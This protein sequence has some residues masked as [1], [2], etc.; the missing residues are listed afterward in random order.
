MQIVRRE[1]AAIAVQVMHR[2]LVGH[3]RRKHMSFIHRERALAQIAGRAGG[4]DIVPGGDAA[5]RA[6]NDMIEGQ[7]VAAAAILAGKPV[8]QKNVEAGKGGV[9]RRLDVGLER[10][11][12]GQS[13]FEAGTSYR[14]IIVGD[15]TDPFE[16]HRLDRVLPGP[17]G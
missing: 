17:Q 2:R 6:G 8:A 16:E 7:V 9:G 10:N 13:H 14:L 3:L 12:A 5:T 4:D 1:L 15:D 11:D